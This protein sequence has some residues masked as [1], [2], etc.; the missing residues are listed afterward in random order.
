MYQD[1]FKSRS[2]LPSRF[3]QFLRGW[4]L[5][6]LGMNDTGFSV[7]PA[8]RNRL[9]KLYEHDA[10]RALGV[11]RNALIKRGAVALT[12]DQPIAR[13][14]I[15]RISHAR[16][17][18][19]LTSRP[20]VPKSGR[21]KVRE[22]D[23]GKKCQTGRCEC[24]T[25][26][27]GTRGVVPRIQGISGT[28]TFSS[29]RQFALRSAINGKDS[30]EIASASATRGRFVCFATRRTNNFHYPLKAFRHRLRGTLL[31]RVLSAK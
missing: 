21:R 9:A 7:E 25:Q 17:K 3:E 18:C 5:E 27:P 29:R 10:S 26:L 28:Q 12:T 22:S 19:G 23:T 30:R 2:D 24:M 16:E 15:A 13:R 20:T 4:I 14:T 11:C 8:K 31:A 1:L 6:P